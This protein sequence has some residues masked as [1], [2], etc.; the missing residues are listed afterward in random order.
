MLEPDFDEGY[1]SHEE[2]NIL[3]SDSYCSSMDTI[4]EIFD[5]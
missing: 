5:R 1:S 4:T 3:H 2:D